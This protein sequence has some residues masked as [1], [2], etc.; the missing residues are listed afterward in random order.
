MKDA[1]VCGDIDAHLFSP[2]CHHKTNNITRFPWL[3]TQLSSPSALSAALRIT[4]W[5]HSHV[6]G[7]WSSSGGTFTS[8]LFWKRGWI[9]FPIVYKKNAYCS[10]GDNWRYQPCP[11]AWS[12]IPSYAIP[13]WQWGATFSKSPLTLLISYYTLPLQ[14]HRNIN[15]IYSPATPPEASGRWLPSDRFHQLRKWKVIKT[16]TWLRLSISIGN[17]NCAIWLKFNLH[18]Q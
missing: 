7:S 17:W 9:Q 15:L 11:P 10:Q 2:R 14:Q 8:Q 5:K 3:S 18:H 12:A 13:P 4:I 1:G 16:R 6:N